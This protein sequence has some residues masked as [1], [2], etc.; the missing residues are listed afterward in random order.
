MTDWNI[1][2]FSTQAYKVT[3][4]GHLTITTL[5]LLVLVFGSFVTEAQEPSLQCLQEKKSVIEQC[6]RNYLKSGNYLYYSRRLDVGQTL[7]Q[8]ELYDLRKDL[9][10]RGWACVLEGATDCLN[11]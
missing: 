2:R 4:M 3:N 6:L 11:G 7:S 8:K 10:G 1:S 9:G 5:L